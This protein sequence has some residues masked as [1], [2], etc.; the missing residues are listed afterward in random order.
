MNIDDFWRM[1]RPITNKIKLLFS[2]AEVIVANNLGT[3]QKLTMT[4]LAD[5]T[6]TEVPFYQNY[7]FE[8]SPLP[9]GEALV[10]FQNGN[11]DHGMVILVY[12]GVSRPILL[13]GEV[14]MYDALGQSITIS[15]TG[16][17]IQDL[18][19]NKISTSPLGITIENTTGNQ[20]IIDS[21]GVTFITGD[22]FLWNPNIRSNCPFDGLP[23]GGSTA[24]INKLKGL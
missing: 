17:D 13:P 8:S 16:V 2:L 3:I 19:F 4:G 12:D 22:G 23:H 24:G 5:E 15:A 1:I 7:G 9:G 10:L 6:L 20:I 21:T 18:S 14:S 11:R